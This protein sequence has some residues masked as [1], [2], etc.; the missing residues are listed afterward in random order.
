[1]AYV[2]IKAEPPLHTLFFQE[3]T[4]FLLLYHKL[5]NKSSLLW[6]IERIAAILLKIN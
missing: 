6:G 5:M 4:W 3:K 1:M 2:K